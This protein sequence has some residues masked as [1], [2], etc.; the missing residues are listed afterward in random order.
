MEISGIVNNADALEPRV[1]AKM[2]Q[3][4]RSAG[5]LPAFVAVVEFGQPKSVF[6]RA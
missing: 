6:K 2:K 3:T 5:K 1:K 4:Y